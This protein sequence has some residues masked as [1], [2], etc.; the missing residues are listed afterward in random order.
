MMGRCKF[1]IYFTKEKADAWFDMWRMINETR[2]IR[3]NWSF[4][5]ENFDNLA[6][7][8]KLFRSMAEQ[9]QQRIRTRYLR[10]MSLENGSMEDIPDAQPGVDEEADE[11]L[12]ELDPNVKHQLPPEI[13]LSLS[14]SNL[15]WKTSSGKRS[16][17]EQDAS[18]SKLSNRNDPGDIPTTVDWGMNEY[19]FP[20]GEWEDFLMDVTVDDIQNALDYPLAGWAPYETLYGGAPPDPVLAKDSKV[21]LLINHAPT[22]MFYR[23]DDQDT[24]S[25]ALRDSMAMKVPNSEWTTM[26]A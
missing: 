14:G 5:G 13:A 16:R 18:S 24:L 17:D 21:A 20:R 2:M 23:G 8:L 3:N 26:D 15:D 19:G 6:P 1:P 12:T 22:T 7:S 4:L 11:D 9:N 25:L 10:A